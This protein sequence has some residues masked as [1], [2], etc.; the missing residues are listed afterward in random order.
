MY[1]SKQ[2]IP[3]R[4]RPATP[5][6]ASEA[7][8]LVCVSPLH[9]CWPEQEQSHISSRMRP[10]S[11]HKIYAKLP[12]CWVAKSRRKEL[13]EAL[14]LSL[15]CRERKQAQKLLKALVPQIL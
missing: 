3:H 7:T 4:G 9:E 14:L 6:A 1:L 5:H 8:A 13:A 10:V 2:L 11:K 12:V 15:G